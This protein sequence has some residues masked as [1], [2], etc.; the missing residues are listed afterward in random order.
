MKIKPEVYQ[1]IID[2]AHHL[3]VRV[4]AHIYYLADATALLQAG[5]DILAHGVR[6]QPVND[7]FI[8]LLKSKDAWYIATLDLNEAS[9]IYAQHPD[10]MQTAFFQ[11]ALQPALRT[12]LEDPAWQR[13]TLAEEHRMNLNS[14]AL[15]INQKN[16]R[17]IFDAGADRLR[18]GFGGIP[19]A[20]LRLRRAP[21]AE[22]DDRC[23]YSA[24]GGDHDCHAKCRR[25]FEALGPRRD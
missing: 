4:A 24:I 21:R 22:A 19:R 11:H 20:Y 6:D 7:E 23:R 10:W 12:Q 15:G 17:V 8:Q 2:E 18:H 9:F 3:R 13:K 16:L 25:T 1:A 14:R 5:V